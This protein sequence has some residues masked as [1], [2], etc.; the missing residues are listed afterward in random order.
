MPM[1]A[2][3]QEEGRRVREEVP[4][5]DGVSGD[6]IKEV[7]KPKVKV[8]VTLQN[9]ARNTEERQGQGNVWTAGSMGRD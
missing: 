8:K 5:G 9:L 7:R 1:N 3:R 6:G 2:L 4:R